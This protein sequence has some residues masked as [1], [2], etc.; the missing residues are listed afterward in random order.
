MRRGPAS[1]PTADDVAKE[2]AI[3][4]AHKAAPIAIA[5]EGETRFG[6]ALETLYVPPVHPD[7][8]FVLCALAGHVFGYEA[9]LAIDATGASAARGPRRDRVGGE[10]RP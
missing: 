2:L 5:D 8:A 7:L 9:A 6:A 1:A 4:R 3:F 10:R